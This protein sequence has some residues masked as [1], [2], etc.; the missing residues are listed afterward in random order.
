VT[1]MVHRGENDPARSGERHVVALRMAA[2]LLR[3]AG[4]DV[5]MLGGDVPPA[6]LSLAAKHHD[7]HVVCL[8]ATMPG[9]GDQ[10]LIAIHEVQQECP[11]AG[12]VLGGRGLASRVRTQPD[13][14]VCERVGEAVEAA[15]AAVKRA[16]LN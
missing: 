15:D 14:E 12:F 7:P 1:A 13:V 9:G 8:S 16:H 5:V 11:G 3:D 6:A 4:Y 10:V 2:N